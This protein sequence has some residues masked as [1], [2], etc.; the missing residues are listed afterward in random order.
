MNLEDWKVRRRIVAGI[1]IFCW[2][3][4]GIFYLTEPVPAEAM[5]LAVSLRIGIVM[6]AL[7][8]AMPT[9]DR[10]AAWAN[11]S[12]KWWVTFLLGTLV[13]LW[14]PKMAPF[15][16]AVFGVIGFLWKTKK[17]NAGSKKQARGKQQAEEA[18][19]ARTSQS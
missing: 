18:E 5:S 19:N 8:L 16:F 7:W 10:P 6:S 11:M 12:A 9:K 17:S 2:I 1:A 4:T 3:L 15:I 13:S 14:R